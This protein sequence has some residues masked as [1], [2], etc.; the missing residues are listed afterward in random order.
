[1]QVFVPLSPK[2]VKVCNNRSYKIVICAP[3]LYS[4]GGVERVV[5]V[6]A[7]YFAD[8]LGFN[9]TIIVTEGIGRISYFPLS[10]RIK[11]INLGLNFE[12]LWHQSFY[13][14]VLL[15]IKKQRLY[16][17]L[18]TSEL[19]RI[20]P[21]ITISVLRREINFI[22]EIKDG[23]K[24]VGELHVNRKNYRNFREGESNV[25]KHLFA[26]FWAWNLLCHLR[27]LDKMV[28]L[29]DC[30]LDDWPELN[31]MIK[32][33][34]PLPFR[35]GEKSC[36][37]QNRVISIGRYDYDKGNDLLL[38]VWTYVEKLMLEWQL[39]IYGDGCREPYQILMEQLGVD[40]SRCHLFG[41]VSDVKQEYLKSSV[42]VLPSRFEGF[43]LVLIEAMACG[44]PV[45]SFDCENGPRSI[46]TDGFDGFL[47]SPFDVK[48]FAE[49]VIL[50]MKNENLRRE[51]GENARR[52]AAKYD[53]DIVGQQWKQLFDELMENR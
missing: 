37:A 44:V 40:S 29:T 12:E 5:S 26:K 43:G 18:L 51:M 36:L 9:V 52:S 11:V 19:M 3:S 46:I 28:V 53:I 39:D 20:H 49:K 2:V 32:I 23:S 41:P 38:Q 33:P 34:D 50:L 1:V 7:N 4:I 13:K 25:L 21:D 15:Y 24:K 22:T 6:K 10:E 35:L 45:V 27:K 8:V 48:A 31:N 14:K 42:F 17:K 47:I 30:A 16:K